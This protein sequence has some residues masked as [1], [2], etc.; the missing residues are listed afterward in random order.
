MHHLS[1]LNYAGREFLAVRL[2]GNHNLFNEFC[3]ALGVER[4]LI[5]A[6][7]KSQNPTA[8]VIQEFAEKPEATFDRL[9]EALSNIG[10]HDMFEQLQIAISEPM[11]GDDV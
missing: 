7:M 3:L 2:N 8:Y 9:E 1:H 4:R 5:Q 6:S 11:N 10:H